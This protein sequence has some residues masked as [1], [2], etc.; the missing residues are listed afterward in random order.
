[1]ANITKRRKGE[2]IRELFQ[3]L[4]EH[5]EGMRAVEALDVLAGRVTM[6]E[7]ELGNYATGGRRFEK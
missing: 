5:P 4:K 7:F 3:I 1:M 2:L 6:T